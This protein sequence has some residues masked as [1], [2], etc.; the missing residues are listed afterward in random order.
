MTKNYKIAHK[1]QSLL[2]L[3]IILILFSTDIMIKLA[4]VNFFDYY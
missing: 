4:K 2:L 1:G 3:S